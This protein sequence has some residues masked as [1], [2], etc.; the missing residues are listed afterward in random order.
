MTTQDLPPASCYH[1]VEADPSIPLL[2]VRSPEEF[3]AGHPQ[4]AR[5]VPVLFRGGRGAEPNDRFVQAVEVLV[6]DKSTRVILSCAM[7]GRS[8]R[9][10]ELLEAAGYTTTINLTGGFHGKRDPSGQ[11]E[12]PGWVDAGLPTST[13]VG[14]R[15]WS[16]VESQ[17][18]G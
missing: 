4:G 1:L 9:A 14:D 16:H 13:D 11:L 12:A 7:G 10:C 3:A 6:P 2:D 15:G 17:L 18:G 5:N 8:R